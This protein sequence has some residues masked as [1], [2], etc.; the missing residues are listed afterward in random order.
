LLS[1]LIQ[2]FQTASWDVWTADWL[3]GLS[4]YLKYKVTAP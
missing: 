1:D 4:I 3:Y 2:N